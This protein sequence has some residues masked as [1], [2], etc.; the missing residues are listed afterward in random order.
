MQY[1]AIRHDRL[2]PC[3]GDELSSWGGNILRR[4]S[5]TVVLCVMACGSAAGQALSGNIAGSISD[6]SAASVA[7]ASV[8]LLAGAFQR[9]PNTG[10]DSGGRG[11]Q[12]IIPAGRP[13]SLWLYSTDIVLAGAGDV[14]LPSPA[15][16]LPFQASAGQDQ[17]FTLT[18]ASLAMGVAHAQ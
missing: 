5:T 4:L 13:F 16:G 11:Y 1:P 15:A 14:L 2:G 9:A 10:A 8:L 3:R 6:P 7:G 17:N 12:M 18:V